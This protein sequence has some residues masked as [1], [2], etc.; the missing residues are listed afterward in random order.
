M[1]IRLWKGLGI[2]G[3]ELGTIKIAYIN[4]HKLFPIVFTPVN[5][6]SRE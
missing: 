1:I 2:Y 4:G 6:L 5:F 3:T